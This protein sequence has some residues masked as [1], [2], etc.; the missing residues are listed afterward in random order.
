V[1]VGG[2]VFARVDC[3]RELLL[4]SLEAFE[5]VLV[6]DCG[7]KAEVKSVVKKK[8]VACKSAD[9]VDTWRQGYDKQPTRHHRSDDPALNFASY[10]PSSPRL[11]L[12]PHHH[13][14]PILSV[15]LSINSTIQKAKVPAQLHIYQPSSPCT[16]TTAQNV[17]P[18]VTVV[19]PAA[20]AAL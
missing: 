19:S 4:P 16:A 13:S 11:L 14:S 20:H 2:V 9:A 17:V 1:S 3:T 18:P 7:H 10:L 12:S 8:H 6:G 15:L 5:V